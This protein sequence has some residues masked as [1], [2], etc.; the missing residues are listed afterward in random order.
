MDLRRRSRQDVI[1]IPTI[2]LAF[3]LSAIVHLV[4]LFAWTAQTPLL[5]KDRIGQGR[6]LA[7]DLAPAPARIA[8]ATIARPPAP[9]PPRAVAP[10]EPKAVA[11]AKCDEARSR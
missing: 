2:W 1:A 5:A 11:P 3:V 9:E 10:P 7:V 4:A 8:E 6:P